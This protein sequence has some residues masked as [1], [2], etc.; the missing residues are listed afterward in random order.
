MVTL[1]DHRETCLAF[2][3][4]H[5]GYFH[6]LLK[7]FSS[8]MI[9]ADDNCKRREVPSPAAELP[10]STIIAASCEDTPALIHRCPMAEIDCSMRA[11]LCILCDRDCETEC[12]DWEL[13]KE[14]RKLMESVNEEPGAN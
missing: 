3:R 4:K 11:L 1:N 14:F 2:L 5:N 13:M 8:M 12:Q 6:S 10:V 7:G 9:M